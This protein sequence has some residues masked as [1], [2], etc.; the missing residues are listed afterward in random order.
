MEVFY[1]VNI[2]ADF[3]NV[4]TSSV[5][6]CQNGHSCHRK[7]LKKSSK[8]W[9]SLNSNIWEE[10][11][12][13]LL[14]SSHWQFLTVSRNSGRF[15]SAGKVMLQCLVYSHCRQTI[16]DFSRTTM[17]YNSSWKMPSTEPTN[18]PAMT[19]C[20]A[21]SSYSRPK[22][23]NSMLST[24]L[25]PTLYTA[26]SEACAEPSLTNGIYTRRRKM[27]HCACSEV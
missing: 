27:V 23:T 19:D 10:P 4:L 2:I 8:S 14:H 21:Y 17:R 7:V 9:K 16:V 13:W 18:L 12:P 22:S 26:Q 3:V 6:E 15:L 5:L 20:A 11:A 1:F 25:W 24:T